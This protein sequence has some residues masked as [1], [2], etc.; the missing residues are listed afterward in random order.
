[1][2]PRIQT[3]LEHAGT[4][5]VSHFGERAQTVKACEEMGE[6][7]TQLMKRLNDNPQ[8]TRESVV[9][10]IAD[11]LITVSQLRILFG[12]DKVD[13][14]ILFKLDRMMTFIRSRNKQIDSENQMPLPG[15][16]EPTL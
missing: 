7:I 5:I 8:A 10:E 11:V 9:D 15:I 12:A 3:A 6:L 13:E 1:M 16:G 4:S 2:N 14:R